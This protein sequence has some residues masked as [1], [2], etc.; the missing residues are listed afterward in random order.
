MELSEL[1]SNA[2]GKAAVMKL[3]A[4]RPMGQAPQLLELLQPQ[5]VRLLLVGANRSESKHDLVALEPQ[6]CSFVLR[7]VNGT[8]PTACPSTPP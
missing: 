5:S 3:I 8:C 1:F 2:F 6:F 4:K 7:V